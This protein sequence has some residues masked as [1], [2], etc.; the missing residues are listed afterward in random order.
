[1]EVTAADSQGIWLTPIGTSVKL[2]SEKFIWTALAP[3]RWEDPDWK[4]Q[5]EKVSKQRTKKGG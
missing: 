4:S 1:M 3:F 5:F 2:K